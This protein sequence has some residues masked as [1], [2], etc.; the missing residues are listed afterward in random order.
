MYRSVRI[1]MEVGVIVRETV[2]WDL[3]TRTAHFMYLKGCCL[4]GMVL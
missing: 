2:D 3:I 1:K 4:S